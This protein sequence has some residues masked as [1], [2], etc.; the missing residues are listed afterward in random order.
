MTLMSAIGA[1]G[2]GSRDAVADKMTR[3]AANDGALDAAARP[4]VRRAGETG[5]AETN[6]ERS[7]KSVLSQQ[8]SSFHQMTS[9]FRRD[10]R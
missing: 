8:L 3:D 9:F 1:S 10:N 7:E 6:E 2:G 5:G 4:C